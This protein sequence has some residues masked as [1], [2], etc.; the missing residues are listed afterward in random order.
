M[1]KYVL[2]FTLLATRAMAEGFNRPIPQ[3][4]S[5]TAEFWYGLASLVLCLSLYAV[6]W[7]VT[8]KR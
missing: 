1:L 8:R 2:T 5:A 3:A 7:M 6:Y 4:Q